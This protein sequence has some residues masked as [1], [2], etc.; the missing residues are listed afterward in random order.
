MVCR[1]WHFS[2]FSPREKEKRLAGIQKY[3]RS[4]RIHQRGCKSMARYGQ[5]FIFSFF[6]M[7]TLNIFSIKVSSDLLGFFSLVFFICVHIL[8]VLSSFFSGVTLSASATLDLISKK[9][10]N[11]IVGRWSGE[12]NLIWNTTTEISIEIGAMCEI[13]FPYFVFNSIDFIDQ[14]E[15]YLKLC[16]DPIPRIKN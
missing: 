11:W 9:K 16:G 5:L 6:R 12:F 15:I 7:L 1:I 4:E 3:I 8:F 2:R 14:Y 13:D 10:Y